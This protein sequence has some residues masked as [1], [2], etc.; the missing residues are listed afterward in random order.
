[1]IKV[2][3]D[4]I[5]E[6]FD[7]LND[8]LVTVLYRKTGEIITLSQEY[9][10][11]ADDEDYEADALSDWEH[12]EI[13]IAKDIIE[14]DSD[15]IHFPD[16]T[17]TDK[18]RVMQDFCKSVPDENARQILLTSINGKGAFRNFGDAVI[19]LGIRDKWFEFKEEAL[20]ELAADWCKR[21]NIEYF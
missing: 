2:K 20:K 17:E 13:A 19:K 11:Y 7:L 18:Y 10:S 1:M 15:Y 12:E 16:P 6:Q 8:N 3:L 5:A 9:M 21:N 4:E 14:N